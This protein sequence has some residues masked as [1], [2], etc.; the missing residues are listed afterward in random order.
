MNRASK[1]KRLQVIDK[2]L[3]GIEDDEWECFPTKTEGKYFVRKR[4]QPLV[5]EQPQEPI[6]YN[7]APTDASQQQHQLQQKPQQQQQP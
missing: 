7:D 1:C 4:K 2:Y 6:A 5:K 3:K